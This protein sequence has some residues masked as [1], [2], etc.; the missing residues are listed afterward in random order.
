MKIGDAVHATVTAVTKKLDAS[1]TE[2][3][4]RPGAGPAGARALPA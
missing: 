4:A 2:D 3:V 1:P